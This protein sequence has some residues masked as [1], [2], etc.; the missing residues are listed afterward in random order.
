M[1]TDGRGVSDLIHGLST[2]SLAADPAD[3]LLFAPAPGEGGGRRRLAQGSWSP[4]ATTAA[5]PVQTAPA[6]APAPARVAPAAPTF[7]ALAGRRRGTTHPTAPG[8]D[9]RWPLIIATL[10]AGILGAF[11]AAHFSPL[12]HS[13]IS[14]TAAAHLPTAAAPTVT[15]VVV[16]PLP[17][18]ARAAPAPEPT[19]APPPPAAPTIAEPPPTAAAAEPSEPAAAPPPTPAK[20]PARRSHHAAKHKATKHAVAHRA[21]ASKAETPKPEPAAEAEEAPPAKP[22]RPS[23]PARASAQADDGENPI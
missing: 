7:A 8:R 14:D 10:A 17:A 16:E 5:P 22:A 4:T 19:V 18:P 3:D 6:V 13:G 9:L 11:G 21:N 23:R 20:T 1:P 15:P 12:G 2:R